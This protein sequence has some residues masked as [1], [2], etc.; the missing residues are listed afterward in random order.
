MIPVSSAIDAHAQAWV[1]KEDLLLPYLQ[2]F[3]WCIC[4]LFE[5]LDAQWKVSAAPIN[6]SP[7]I[8]SP[9]IQHSPRTAP[10]TTSSSPGY[11]LTSLASLP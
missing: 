3:A 7:V 11:R 4:S 1:T 8:P 10:D 9:Y 5:I 6:S 2:A